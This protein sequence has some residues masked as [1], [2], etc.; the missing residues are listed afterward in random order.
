MLRSRFLTA[1]VAIPL[2]VWLIFW[3]SSWVFN[4]VVLLA[5][6]VALREFSAMALGAVRGAATLTTLGGMSIAA[7]MGLVQGGMAASTGISA[8]IVACLTLTLLGTL[9]TATDMNR[10][11]QNAGQILLGAL[12]GGV[13]LPH[14]IWL[15]A[16]PEKG[17]AWVFFVFAVSMASDVGGYFGGG[18]LGNRKL[19]PSVSPNKTVEGA[20]V[21]FLSGL[22]AGVV[23]DAIILRSLGF[24][25]ALFV[26]GL[27]ALLAQL[28]DLL[29][30]MLKRAYGVKDSGWLLPGHGGVLDRTDSLVLPIVFVY[31]YA[32]LVIG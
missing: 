32:I 31:Y 30:S 22:F 17:P 16:L 18:A 8:G 3:A 4:F 15:R 19:W 21:S 2:L 26:A 12:Y 25:Q 13:L 29:E 6:F 5:T 9:A 1:L 10:S 27:I 11:V 7:A 14:L 28:G 20:A 24:L 23:L